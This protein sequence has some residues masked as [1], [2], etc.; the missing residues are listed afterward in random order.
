MRFVEMPEP[1]KRILFLG[2]IVVGAIMFIYILVSN[3]TDLSNP[4]PPTT[5]PTRTP[6]PTKI[7]NVSPLL[8][9]T[10]L[11]FTTD[12]KQRAQPS[13]QVTDVLQNMHLQI[14]RISFAENPSQTDIKNMALYV[15]SLKAVPLVPLHGSL[16]AYAQA[17]NTLVVQTMKQVFG[18]TTVYYEYGDEED[19]L[20]VSAEQYT[21]DWNANIPPLKRLAPNGQFIGPVTYHYDQN[22][23]RSFLRNAQPLPNEVSWHEFTCDGTWSKQQCINGISAWNQHI[24]SARTLMKGLLQTTLPIMITEWNYAANAQ[25]SDGKGNDSTFLTTWTKSAMQTLAT[26]QVFASM[27][28][29]GTKSSTPTVNSNDQIMVQ[30]QVMRSLYEQYFSKPGS[31]GSTSTPTPTPT[32]TPEPT[33]TPTPTPTPTPD[34]TDTGAT[35]ETPPVIPPT[36][37]VPTPTPTRVVVPTPTPIPTPTPPIPVPTPTPTSLITPT[38]TPTDG[39]TPTA[40]PNPGVTP[41][42]DTPPTE[43]I[44]DP[45]PTPTVE[46]PEPTPPP[47]A[48]EPTPTPTATPV[49]PTPTPTP[50]KPTPTPTPKPKTCTTGSV[51]SNPIYHGNGY[52]SSN[53]G[54][55]R[56]VS[57]NCGGKVYFAFSS[58][59]SVKDT[60]VRL[61]TASG[62]CGSWVKYTSVGSKLLIKSGLSAGTSFHL[63]FQGNGA[64]ASYKVSGNIYY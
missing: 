15:Q 33:D 4:S 45:T 54:T 11:D 38:T 42:V 44:P 55:Y 41:T 59:P 60:E 9:G 63:Q 29:S 49:P 43:T 1:A 6:A 56:T 35:T 30:G 48:E 57:G 14:I 10:N 28:Y 23:L 40:T 22:Y 20:G 8:F 13:T 5:T 2:A 46:T 50:A 53:G 47:T 26:N 36:I 27:Q 61:C 24:A 37:P 64:T 62:S 19:V 3:L 21:A 32:A 7:A 51:S 12:T 52:A 39:T 25:N 16:Y 34:T 58:A 17:D 31:P 18:N